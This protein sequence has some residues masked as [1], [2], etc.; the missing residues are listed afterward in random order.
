M[1]AKTNGPEEAP[2]EVGRDA[3]GDREQRCRSASGSPPR[4]S[5]P[6]RAARSGSRGSS[7][8]PPV[9]QVDRRSA[10]SSCRARV[11]SARI[12][13]RVPLGRIGSSTSTQRSPS[14]TSVR[15]TSSWRRAPVEGR[16][17]ACTT[18]R[19]AAE[20]RGA[21]RATVVARAGR[22]T[23]DARWA[24]PGPSPPRAA[25]GPAAA[26]P[27]AP[28]ASDDERGGDRREQ[29]PGAH[30][31]RGYRRGRSI[32]KIRGISADDD[33]GPQRERAPLE[34]LPRPRGDAAQAPVEGH[35]TRDPQRRA[36]ARRGA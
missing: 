29:I 15:V 24:R 13:P 22:P 32:P 3:L 2:G 36:R 34:E 35:L 9:A 31:P 8:Q 30:R 10:G 26:A 33:H 12:H 28:A 6:G 23:P 16:D 7:D 17:R 18:I 4:R 21:A 20:R 25:A 19:A 27:P 5:P 14:T 1:R 11:T